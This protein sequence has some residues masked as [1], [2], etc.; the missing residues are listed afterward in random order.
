MSPPTP[1]YAERA[2][3]LLEDQLRA[4]PPPG[5]SAERLVRFFAKHRTQIVHAV[6]TLLQAELRSQ[7]GLMLLLR[8][9]PNYDFEPGSYKAT[10]RLAPKWVSVS[11]LGQAQR[12]VRDYIDTHGLG[13]GNWTGGEVFRE[14]QPYARISYN[15]RIWDAVT[16]GE[17]DAQGHPMP[18]DSRPVARRTGRQR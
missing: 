18:S 7:P 10:V 13:G 15:G 16:E 1:S 9:D 5:V 12:R 14:G 8:A 2:V 3:L 17:L 11:S 6:Q 4:N